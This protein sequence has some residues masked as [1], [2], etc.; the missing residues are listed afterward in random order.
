MGHTSGFIHSL[1]EWSA[2]VGLFKSWEEKKL[3]AV[4]ALQHMVQQK[5]AD[6]PFW[7]P[8]SWVKAGGQSQDDSGKNNDSD[9]WCKHW[10]A[11]NNFRHHIGFS[12]EQI[13]GSVWGNFLLTV[14]A[15]A[16]Y[17]PPPSS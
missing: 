11:V 15:S 6:F 12:C 3:K 16:P 17:L 14:A 2:S 7:E 4:A 10:E 8:I 13:L 9:E 5:P 1:C